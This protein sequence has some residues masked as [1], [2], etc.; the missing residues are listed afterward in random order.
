MVIHSKD[1]SIL[2]KELFPFKN[3]T[4]NENII[5]GIVN[6]GGH[7]CYFQGMLG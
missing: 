1:D 5:V 3:L 4:D 7:V 2:P 6:R